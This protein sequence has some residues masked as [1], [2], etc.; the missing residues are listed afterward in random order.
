LADQWEKVHVFISSTFNDMHAERDYLV[1]RVFPELRDWCE[2]RKLRLVEVDLRWGVTEEDATKNINV[3]RTCLKRIDDCRPFFVCLL[4]QR[5]GWIPDKNEVSK[6]TLEEFPLLESSFE[7]MMSITEMEILHAIVKPFNEDESQIAREGKTQHAFFYLRE[8]DYLKDLPDSPAKLKKIYA[9]ADKTRELKRLKEEIINATG[10]PVRKYQTRWDADSRTPELNLPLECPALLDENVAYWQRDWGESLKLDSPLSGRTVPIELALDAVAYNQQLTQGR[11]TDF[12][13]EGKPLHEVVL[14][15][16]QAAISQRYPTHREVQQ[17]TDLQ[18]ELDQQE[19]FL[20]NNSEGFIERGNDFDALDAYIDGKNQN[21]FVLTADGGFGKSMLLAKWVDRCR[22]DPNRARDATFHVRFVGQSDRSNTVTGLLYYLLKDLQDV[23]H[24]IPPQEIPVEAS[25]LRLYWREQLQNLGNQGKTIIVIDAINEFETGLTDLSWVPLTGLP[26]NVKFVV[27]FRTGD[28]IANALYQRY[29]GNGHI[30]ISQVKPF[31]NPQDRRLLVEDYLSNFLKELD[32]QHIEELI[33]AEGA[34]NPLFLKVVLSELRIFGAFAQLKAKIKNDFGTNPESAFMALLQRLEK[35]PVYSNVPPEDSIPLFF[36]FLLHARHGLTAIELTTLLQKNLPDMSYDWYEVFESVQLIL[37]QVKTFVGR[38]EGRYYLF[39][40][41]FQNA[42]RDRYVNGTSG[43]PKFVSPG[44]AWHQLLA[45]IFAEQPLFFTVDQEKTVN[46][47]KLAE[48]PYQ[49]A[50]AKLWKALQT[51]LTDFNF[52][53]AK[54]RAGWLEGLMQDYEIAI[55]EGYPQ[56][57][58]A[59]VQNAIR[60]SVHVIQKDPAQTSGQLIGRL[61]SAD[62][63]SIR[64]LRSQC[65]NWDETPWLRPVISALVESGTAL[66]RTISGFPH[67]I[68]AIALDEQ[69]NQLIVGCADHS[70]SIWDLEHFELL[71]TVPL[72]QSVDDAIPG[73]LDVRAAMRISGMEGGLADISKQ[74]YFGPAAIAVIPNTPFLLLSII[75]D[76]SL[77]IWDREKQQRVGVLRGHR[78]MITAAKVTSDGRYALSASSDATVRVW[79][80]RQNSAVV[81]PKFT[82]AKHTH[83]VTCLAVTQDDQ[84]VVSGSTDKTIRVWEIKSG[85]HLR[86][87]NTGDPIG[88]VMVTPDNRYIISATT[89]GKVF[90]WDFEQQAKGLKAL[91]GAGKVHELSGLKSYPIALLPIG[92]QKLLTAG[93]KEGLQIWDLLTGGH[94]V[95]LTDEIKSTNVITTA[96]LDHANKVVL[97]G[98]TNRVIKLFSYDLTTAPP[99]VLKHPG[100]SRCLAISPDGRYSISGTLDGEIIVWDLE[101]QAVKHSLSG[102]KDIIRDVAVSQQGSRLVSCGHD[103]TVRV[104]D[105]MSGQP[106]AVFKEHSREVFSVGISD[107]GRYAVSGGADFTIQIWDIEA[108]KHLRVISSHTS[109]ITALGISGTGE[110]AISASLDGAVRIWDLQS[111]SSNMAVMMNALF[112]SMGGSQAGNVIKYEGIINVFSIS[113]DG[114]TAVS[115]DRDGQFVLWDLEQ[116][117][118]E[119]LCKDRLAVW[120]AA[121]VTGSPE[122]CYCTRG[123]LLEL[124]HIPKKKIE[125]TFTADA[126]LQDCAT[127]A[128]GDVVISNDIYGTIYIHKLMAF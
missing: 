41:S 117:T 115:G 47:R 15:D 107:D 20:F 80:I 54:M 52:I 17:A 2:K 103:Q 94:I 40:E 128:A 84:Y 31:D 95:D 127:N 43:D 64:R 39:F 82:L 71:K 102:H 42:V 69:L 74:V 28:E 60:M 62:Y 79:D 26:E 61:F 24:K 66:K 48:L 3:V 30:T 33:S 85:K 8:D 46:K 73:N 126:V 100:F 90:V 1:K 21:L 11:L 119:I 97:S 121:Y 106:L 9:D 57:D 35:D 123:P 110:R 56:H 44:R 51:T 111:A 58:L 124:W 22:K 55:S 91:F 5:Y 109:S 86:C 120:G 53:A 98:G 78:G 25:A 45:D 32:S 59:L 67:A 50:H 104:W 34:N 13:V 89:E 65:K 18:E 87:I 101:K 75:R 112:S 37:R 105:W 16:L 38:R 27:S 116:K 68:F 114:K 6:K 70:L 77:W 92:D 14:E 19:I 76:M 99:Q 113:P 7:K 96:V 10:R 49:R 4:G 93:S 108:K 88:I 72:P 122:R 63:E 23:S 81:S 125:A 83:H 12:E 36:G 118:Y 29:A